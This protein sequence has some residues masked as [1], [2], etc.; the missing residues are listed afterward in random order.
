MPYGTKEVKKKIGN[1]M[2]S[3]DVAYKTRAEAEKDAKVAR[4][5]VDNVH[6]TKEAPGIYR[7]WTY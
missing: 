7:M 3:T 5:I 6:I 1:H 4:K 2:Y